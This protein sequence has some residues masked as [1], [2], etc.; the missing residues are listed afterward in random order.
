VQRAPDIRT[1]LDLAVR[2]YRVHNRNA[3]IALRYAILQQGIEGS[4]HI[5]D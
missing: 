4:E 1:A 5:L 3:M 2:H